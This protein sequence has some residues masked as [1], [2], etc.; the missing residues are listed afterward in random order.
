M[1]EGAPV[2]MLPCDPTAISQ[3]GIP[4]ADPCWG[5]TAL[6]NAILKAE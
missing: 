5:T 3:A 6:A 2:R 1:I 4:P